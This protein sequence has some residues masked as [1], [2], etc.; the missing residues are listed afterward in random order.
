V[1]WSGSDPGGPGV[2]SFTVQ[3]ERIGSRHR[4]QSR[5]YPWETLRGFSATTKTSVRFRGHG[6]TYRFRVRATDRSGVTGRW[7]TTASV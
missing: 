1:R 7:A 4:R 2:A 3:I 5:A 6:G